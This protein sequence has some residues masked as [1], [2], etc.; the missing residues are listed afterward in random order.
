MVQT[1]IFKPTNSTLLIT[2]LITASPKHLLEIL[3]LILIHDIK[4]S[5][6]LFCLFLFCFCF[7]VVLGVDMH[8]NRDC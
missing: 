5:N 7:C 3:T 2:I 8:K 1:I 4:N 6:Q